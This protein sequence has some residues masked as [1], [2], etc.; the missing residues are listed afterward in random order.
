MLL[1][2]KD[3]YRQNFFCGLR[4]SKMTA[5]RAGRWNETHGYWV[6]PYWITIGTQV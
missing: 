2:P 6:D 3:D 1:Y 4:A 5:H